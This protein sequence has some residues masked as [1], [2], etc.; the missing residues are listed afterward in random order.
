MRPST[1]SKRFNYLDQASYKPRN[2]LPTRYAPNR[3]YEKYEQK[4]IK[5]TVAKPKS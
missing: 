3:T 1:A 2:D 5:P 4:V